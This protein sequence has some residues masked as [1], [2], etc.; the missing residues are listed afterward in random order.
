MCTLA[1]FNNSFQNAVKAPVPS[2]SL[3]S[4]HIIIL[5]IFH[6]FKEIHVPIRVVCDD[7]IYCYTVAVVDGQRAL[8]VV[9]NSEFLH[10][11]AVRPVDTCFSLSLSLSLISY[12]FISFHSYLQR[13][14]YAHTYYM[15]PHH[16]PLH[17]CYNGWSKSVDNCCE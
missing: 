15:T 1:D 13:N 12:Y 8:V 6:T 9:V 10:E 7:I 2:L 14:T 17:R 3:S 5:L 11:R 4:S 16:S